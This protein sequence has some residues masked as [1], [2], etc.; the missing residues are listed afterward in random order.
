MRPMKIDTHKLRKR[1]GMSQAEL[2][3]RLGLTQ[4]T[5]SRWETNGRVSRLG[6]KLLEDI[7][8]ELS[9]TGAAK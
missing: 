6:V 8:P 1:L 3:H 5:V 7:E 9:S 4:A 2:A